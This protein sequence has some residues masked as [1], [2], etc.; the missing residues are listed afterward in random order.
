MNI[1]PGL[2]HHFGKAARIAFAPSVPGTAAAN[3]RSDQSLPA[4]APGPQAPA[5]KAAAA[6]RLPNDHKLAVQAVPKDDF[7]RFR[8]QHLAA[9]TE[10]NLELELVTREGDRIRLDFSQVDTSTHTTVAG[11][12]A[13][14]N[15]FRVLHSGETTQRL[16]SMS[17]EGDLSEAEQAAVD[18]ALVGIV[19]LA[20]A[21][22]GTT[23]GSAFENVRQMDF[24][25]A[26]LL[27]VSVQMSHSQSLKVMGSYGVSAG[28]LPELAS[29]GGAFDASLGELG[30]AQR[31]L[32][33]M[34]RH[35]FDDHSA[36]KLVRSLLPSV[37]AEPAPQPAATAG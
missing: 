2:G 23:P 14:G 25:M 4:A 10:T 17:V 31:G 34:A 15:R 18:A 36:A 9:S 12:D 1:H 30:D 35:V 13:D 37:L 32:V 7:V 5:T 16:V 26:A 27:N 24:D 20:N 3:G 22:F 21:F 33:N 8:Q 28:G 29:R 6:G 19:D 11:K